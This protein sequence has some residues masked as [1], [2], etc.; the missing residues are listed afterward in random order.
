MLSWTSIESAG[1]HGAHG[2]FSSWYSNGFA[3]AS[4]AFTPAAYASSSARCL[5]G[6]RATARSAI[7]RRPRLAASRSSATPCGTICPSSPAGSRRARSIC[8][9]RSRAWIQPCA[10]TASASVLARMVGISTESRSISTGAAS[11]GSAARIVSISRVSV[12]AARRSVAASERMESGM[13]CAQFR[14]RMKYSGLSARPL[15]NGAA[16]GVPSGRRN[17]STALPLRLPT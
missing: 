4:C 14:L 15:T 10:H 1:V 5:S 9:K 2:A 16:S 8:R 11:A 12:G 6:S 3:T 17:R 7:A 13:A